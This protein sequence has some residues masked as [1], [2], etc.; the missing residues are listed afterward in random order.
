MNIPMNEVR[1][2]LRIIAFCSALLVRGTSVPILPEEAKFL[3]S[4]STCALMLYVD[5]FVVF[6]CILAFFSVNIQSTSLHSFAVE[7]PFG[8]RIS[9][10]DHKNA[11]FHRLL[12]QRIPAFNSD[13]YFILLPRQCLTSTDLPKPLPLPWSIGNPADIWANRVF[14][15]MI[16]PLFVWFALPSIIAPGITS[17]VCR[18]FQIKLNCPFKCP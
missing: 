9:L 4:C 12:H 14:T 10:P 7:P 16:A 1:G 11:T 8:I 13:I 18:S 15:M 5:V 17:H 3:I 6:D 2:V